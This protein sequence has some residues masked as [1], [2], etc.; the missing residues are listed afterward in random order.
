MFASTTELLLSA[1]W[2]VDPQKFHQGCGFEKFAVWLAIWFP[3]VSLLLL[4]LKKGSCCFRLLVSI[5]TYLCS[6][7]FFFLPAF[8]RVS[9]KIQSTPTLVIP[10]LAKNSSGS[11]GNS[12]T[13]RDVYQ[14]LMSSI[15]TLLAKTLLSLHEAFQEAGRPLLLAPN[16][17]FLAAERS[18]SLTRAGWKS[19][20]HQFTAVLRMYVPRLFKTWYQDVSTIKIL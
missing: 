10:L 17:D 12:S 15:S 2:T 5:P 18:A 3:Y 20:S 13:N 11:S 16:A 7:Q 4:Y 8:L 19:Q 1:W 9:R 14:I 6:W